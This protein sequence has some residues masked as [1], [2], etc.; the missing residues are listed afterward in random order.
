MY[1]PSG[2]VEQVGWV[3]LNC[4][5]FVEGFSLT[6]NLMLLDIVEFDM[7]LGMD[8]LEDHRAIFDC[9]SKEVLFR[10]PGLPEILFCGDKGSPMP[11]FVSAIKAEK[12]MNKGCEAF[13]S[14]VV[15][16]NVDSP[17]MSRILVVR[18]YPD[19]FPEEL[20]GL[21]P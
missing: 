12:M 4:E 17:N 8:F 10:S 19:V 14:H 9:H 21:P 5:I 18:R 13:L 7:I 2:E 3:Y 1:Y 6:V 16:M 11:C 15:N 20:P